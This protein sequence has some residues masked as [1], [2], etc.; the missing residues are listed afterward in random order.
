LSDAEYQPVDKAAVLE[1]VEQS[2][3]KGCATFTEEI[4]ESCQDPVEPVDEK[5]K[6]RLHPLIWTGIL[7]LAAAVGIILYFH[8]QF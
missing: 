1:M 7:C 6:Y 2:Y 4:K 8:F 5:G 3:S